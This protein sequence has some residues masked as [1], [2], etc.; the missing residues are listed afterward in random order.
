MAEQTN[1][2]ILDGL[3]RDLKRAAQLG[4]IPADGANIS[5]RGEFIVKPSNIED[6]ENE[7]MRR[8]RHQEY[9]KH[10]HGWGVDEANPEAGEGPLFV[11]VLNKEEEANALAVGWSL[12]PL[13]GPKGKLD[14][15]EA[16]EAAA[17]EA[18]KPKGPVRTFAAPGALSGRAGKAAAKAPK[19]ES[20]SGEANSAPNPGTATPKQPKPAT[21]KAKAPKAD[22]KG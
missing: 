13:H 7:K 10:L 4:L 18:P 15:S 19:A 6:Q 5:A 12:E 22:D 20:A 21:R 2:E 9:P 11:E 3:M 8:Y 1:Q 14:G 17:V 16:E